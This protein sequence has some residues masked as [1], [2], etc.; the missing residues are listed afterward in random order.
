M[1]Q[2]PLEAL[3]LGKLGEVDGH[4]LGTIEGLVLGEAEGPVE[5]LL[6]ALRIDE[7]VLGEG[8]GL[9]KDNFGAHPVE[10]QVG[11]LVLEEI[12]G[13][14]KELGPMDELVESKVEGLVDGQI[15]GE[16]G[17][18]ILGGER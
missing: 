14:G 7:P 3:L 16:A 5:G 2:G 1:V 15:L 6:T 9:W 17:G 10:G 11:G 18:L 4:V 12:D 8:L 13:L